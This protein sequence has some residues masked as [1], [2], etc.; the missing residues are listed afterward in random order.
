MK[1]LLIAL[2]PW[3]GLAS[4]AYGGQVR[5]A[6][7]VYTHLNSVPTRA[8][9]V[10]DECFVALEDV[11]RWGWKAEVTGDTVNLTAE[12]Q[13]IKVPMRVFSGR[14][15]IP[16]RITVDK[17]GGKADWTTGTDTLEVYSELTDIT[18]GQGKLD[19]S[20]PLGFTARATLLKRPGRVLIDL[21]GVRVG[22]NTRK[23]LDL[24]TRVQQYRPN[25]TR[26][27][28][29]TEATPDV[30]RLSSD[31]M[32]ALNLVLETKK[33][34]PVVPPVYPGATAPTA[35]SEEVPQTTPDVSLES[36]P[37]ILQQETDSRVSLRVSLSERLTGNPEVRNLDPNTLQIKFPGVQLNLAEGF[38][39]ESNSVTSAQTEIVDGAT[40][41]TLTFARPMGAEVVNQG[42]VVIISLLK[43]NIGDGKLAGKLIVVDPGHGGHDGGSR[44]GGV[45]EKNV[46][47]AIGKLIS[48][49]LT[50]EGATVIMTRTTDVFIPLT[51]RAD[52]ANRSNADFFISNHVNSNAKPGSKSGTITF[53]HKGRDISR[54]LAQ[55]IQTE[56]AKVNKLPDLGAWSDGKIYDTGFSVLRNTRMTGVLLELGFV[57][58]PKDR[59]RMV[60]EEFQRSVAL[61]V[62]RGIKVFL[63]D[64]KKS[65]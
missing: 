3:M 60:T 31:P 4:V 51:Q 61:A 26:I 7:V 62:V 40:V 64:A 12:G 21:T 44:G 56:L 54:I 22:I 52:I 34:E 53:H 28:I 59:A 9:R 16:L 19:L 65:Q 58:H 17:L 37:L 50:A 8:I 11:T 48:A 18:S 25:V 63:G 45:L 29:E 41:L 5:S 55:C 10:G 27:T 14:N 13:D 23:V 49:A 6:D 43:P 30:D 47:L 57:N 36:L 33:P 42:G 24:N 32:R 2:G 38:R 20:A 1:R 35:G 46:N 39:L 15:S